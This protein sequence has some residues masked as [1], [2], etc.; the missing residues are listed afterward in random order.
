MNK[1]QYLFM[2]IAEECSELSQIALKTAQ[3]GLD[4]CH[5]DTGKSNLKRL[6]EEYTDVLAVLEMAV[7]ET[8]VPFVIGDIEAKKRKVNHFYSIS[9]EIGKVE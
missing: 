7:E 3:F 9:K 6:Q 8:N 1:E 2:K 4:S 5:P